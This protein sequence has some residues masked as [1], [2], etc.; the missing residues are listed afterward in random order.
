MRNFAPYLTA[1]P[2]TDVFAAD[3]EQQMSRAKATPHS[4]GPLYPDFDSYMLTPLGYAVSRELARVV[5]DSDQS[6]GHF[7][8]ESNRQVPELVAEGNLYL[9][10]KFP[11]PIDWGFFNP[12]REPM[13]SRDPIQQG[14]VMIAR[15]PIK[16]ASGA[17][18][19]ANLIT[20]SMFNF[21][22]NRYD[23]DRDEAYGIIR[24]STGL[25]ARLAM[26]N[27]TDPNKS[28]NRTQFNQFVGMDDYVD[29][30][31]EPEHLVLDAERTKV[32]LSAEAKQK[33]K[34]CQG[35]GCPSM[36]LP[37]KWR[38]KVMP[39]LMA[40]WDGCSEIAQDRIE[41]ALA[42]PSFY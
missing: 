18:Q 24:N 26:M 4:I 11:R 10:G 40:F 9:Q 15:S 30:V 23:Y 12:F 36:S 13:E 41:Q 31:I 42:I 16:N 7:P 27:D 6:F 14:A 5:A 34:D 25:L 32:D 22:R 20:R 33:A 19:D 35:D 2:E 37:V 39:M 17:V 3:L 21:L 38:G 8:V 28:P 1:A 29:G